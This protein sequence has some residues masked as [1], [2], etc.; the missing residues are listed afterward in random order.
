[1]KQL[2]SLRDSR[3]GSISEKSLE[4]SPGLPYNKLNLVKNPKLNQGRLNKT[5]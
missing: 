1:M 5:N 4:E 3:D 2:H